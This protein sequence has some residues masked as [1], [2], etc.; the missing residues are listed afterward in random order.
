VSL[1]RAQADALLLAR[2]RGKLEFVGLSTTPSAG[3]VACLTGPLLEGLR[4]CGLAPADPTAV[5]D[6]DLAALADADVPRLL[7]AAE[8][9]AL[10]DVLGQ[11]DRAD[12][13]A[14]PSNSFSFG[15]FYA[16]LEKTVERKRAELQ[17]RYGVGLST[18]VGGRLD[19]D[20]Q[21]R[22]PRYY[23]PGWPGYPWP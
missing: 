3:A 9:R 2:C 1:A 16:A 10:E 20:F 13:T 8:L 21:E 17:R 7:D 6:A 4:A 14:G 23:P 12:Q 22:W 18:V 11:W 19:L 5:A 15:S